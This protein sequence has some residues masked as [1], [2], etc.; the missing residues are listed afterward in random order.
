M[1]KTRNMGNG[2]NQNDDGSRKGRETKTIFILF[3]HIINCYVQSPHAW[4][5]MNIDI[6]SSDRPLMMLDL[7]LSRWGVL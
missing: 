4:E 6:S 2:V 3:C 7:T 5:T 1:E